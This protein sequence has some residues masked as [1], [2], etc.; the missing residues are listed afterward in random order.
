MALELINSPHYKLK[1]HRHSY[2]SSTIIL[3]LSLFMVLPGA[4]V[5]ARDPV[6]P[7]LHAQPQPFADLFNDW[8]GSCAGCLPCAGW[9]P[10]QQPREAAGDHRC[11]GDWGSGTL[12]NH[13]HH[14]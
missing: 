11:G 12:Y 3:I 14:D 7:T 9:S 5:W 6:I 13:C 8:H 4:V 10:L 1:D 2:L